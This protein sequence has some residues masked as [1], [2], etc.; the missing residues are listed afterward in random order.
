MD[1]FIGF[2][3]GAILHTCNL[4]S[5]S[6]VIYAPPG[7]L[8][9]LGGTFLGLVTNNVAEYNVFIEIIWDVISHG[10]TYLE[11]RLDSQL[12]VS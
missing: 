1:W 4:A 7:Q 3:D 12:V 9:S 2:I 10:I 5:T 8:V 6:W 11:F